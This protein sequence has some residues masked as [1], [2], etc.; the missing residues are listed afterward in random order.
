[1]KEKN[2]K[3]IMDTDT[4]LGIILSVYWD[5]A[6]KMAAMRPDH[7]FH[8]TDTLEHTRRVVQASQL[9]TSRLELPP[10]EA[11]NLR[12][13]AIAHDLGKVETW[14]PEG[15]PWFKGHEVASAELMIEKGFSPDDDIVNAVRHHGK[16]QNFDQFGDKA[17]RKLIDKIQNLKLFIMLQVCD[18]EG[19]SPY[20]RE[21]ARNQLQMFLDHIDNEHLARRNS[22]IDPLDDYEIAHHD[23]C[24]RWL[25]TLC[26]YYSANNYLSP[27]Q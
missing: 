26:S 1:M 16:L 23:N 13:A 18:A 10:R 14:N 3:D 27:A 8:N 2:H 12:I 19:F 15:S 22:L 9:L 25:E 21:K 5:R 20:G 6:E 17:R 11:I 7:P 4:P 24:W